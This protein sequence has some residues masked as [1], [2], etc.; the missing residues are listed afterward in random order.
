[1]GTKAEKFFALLVKC[2]VLCLQL[3]SLAILCFITALSSTSFDLTT[4]DQ[5]LLADL[6]QHVQSDFDE[7]VAHIEQVAS[8]AHSEANDDEFVR[9]YKEYGISVIGF[10]TLTAKLLYWNSRE[11]IPQYSQLARFGSQNDQEI[12]RAKNRTYVV[13]A[14]TE[15]NKHLGRLFFLIPMKV[16]YAIENEYL[17]NSAYLGK[18]SIF[19]SQP[20]I[21]S[22]ASFVLVKD[23]SSI[24]LRNQYGKIVYG[25]KW[26][27][28]SE[29][30][31]PYQTF[32]SV[33]YALAILF[34]L[35]G[36]VYWFYARYRGRLMYE[37]ALYFIV[38]MFR[39][40]MLVLG[41]PTEFIKIKLFSATTLALDT[42]TPSLGDLLINSVLFIWGAFIL[43]RV[44]AHYINGSESRKVVAYLAMLYLFVS[45]IS[46]YVIS[47]YTDYLILNSKLTFEL[48]DFTKVDVYSILAIIAI[49]L[50]VVAFYL[51]LFSY[52][53]LLKSIRSCGSFQ[54]SLH[55]ALIVVI[56]LG[57]IF[58]DFSVNKGEYSLPYVQLTYV[59]SFV[60]VFL[61][62]Y[63]SNHPIRGTLIS[64]LTTLSLLAGISNLSI[65]VSLEKLTTMN[66]ESLTQRYVEDRNLIT[67][68]MFDGVIDN[69]SRDSSIW[70][71]DSVG[72]SMENPFS[73]IIPQL[74]NKYLLSSFKQYDVRVFAFIGRRRVDNQFDNSPFVLNDQL[75][76]QG[77]TLSPKLFFVPY[78]R[79]VTQNIYVSLVPIE[80]QLY[81]RVILQ[82]ELHPKNYLA[83]MLYPQL[84]L[85]RSVKRR[86][87]LPPKY[88]LAIYVHG[89][90]TRMEGEG[91]FPLK[92]AID[93]MGYSTMRD[94][95]FFWFVKRLNEEKFII[96][97]APKRSTFD[98]VTAFSFLFYLFAILFVCYSFKKVLIFLVSFRRNIYDLNF[99]TRIQLYLVVLTLLPLTAVWLLTTP[100]FEQFYYEETQLQLENN[101]IQVSR[102]LENDQHFMASISRS[103]TDPSPALIDLVTNI[104]ELL[105]SDLNVYRSNGELYIT[106]RPKIFQMAL[107]STIINPLPYITFMRGERTNM[108]VDESIGN[109]SYFSGYSPLVNQAGHITGYLNIPFLSRQDVLKDKLRSFVAYL[110]NVYIIV[111]LILVLA[112]L[113][114]SKSITNPLRLLK[115]KIDETQIGRRPEPLYWKTKDEIGSIIASYNNMLLKLEASEKKLAKSEREMAWKEMARQVAHEIKNPLTPMKL[116]IQ[117]LVRTL[118]SSNDERV[119]QVS[120]KISKTL[121]T[122]IDSLTA[123]ANSFSQFATISVTDKSLF[124]LNQMLEDIQHLYNNSEGIDVTLHLP[125]EDVQLYADRNQLN[126]VLVNL[127]RNSIQADATTVS[128]TLRYGDELTVSITDNGKGIDD[129]I[130]DKIFEPNFSTKTSGMGLGLAICRRII[131]AMGGTIVF[132]SKL[133]VGTTFYLS[134]PRSD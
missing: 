127:I 106:T 13:I 68:S 92:Y 51:L 103:H 40:L 97:R 65:T 30:R 48:S 124:S 132:E 102:F 117:H 34:L 67:E 25:L 107:A 129:A 87:I 24:V 101:L 42:F 37:I 83:G 60:V 47:F 104:S 80:S 20:S 99:T 53:L 9:L 35:L 36:V 90:L 105:F 85:D 39:S 130:K 38:L 86:L 95:N 1:M 110:V 96:A 50:S 28:A 126:R 75:I 120:D 122:Q 18:P 108:I 113:F 100:L 84:L 73:Y 46:C 54:P 15:Y 2:P 59:V 70:H 93:D 69:M 61:L 21:T 72:L 63:V 133:G 22:S 76:A 125:E 10:D 41:Y 26:R 79:S 74:L 98:K 114:I 57:W 44:S 66:L 77:R 19:F 131:E 115:Q 4:N 55:V 134:F 128:V 32:S 81:G 91:D 64:S 31:E 3:L 7:L 11:Y 88:G 23:S 45:I 5:A 94:D 17:V 27:N 43:Y 78:G 118:Q 62:A 111:I 112:S 71:L 16:E 29:I 58:Y 82:I 56:M 49:L 33:L 89:N 8:E 14:T 12:L 119:K 123:I 109:L 116:S 6:E 121:L 52:A